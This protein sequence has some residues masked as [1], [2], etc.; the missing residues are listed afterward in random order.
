MGNIRQLQIKNTAKRLLEIHGDKFRKNDF[1]HNKKMVAEYTEVL[2]KRIR[3][4]IAGYIT[5]LLSPRKKSEE[6][7]NYE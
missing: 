2:G 4:R 7:I 1:N 5:R 3:N 6:R